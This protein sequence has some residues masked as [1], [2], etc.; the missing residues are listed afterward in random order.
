MTNFTPFCKREDCRIS[1]SGTGSITAAYFEP[2]YDKHG[3]NLNPDRNVA[4]MYY[5]CGICGKSWNVETCAGETKIT[6][7][8]G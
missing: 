4:T 3:N 7:L 6:N 5:N 1:G 2:V 8:R